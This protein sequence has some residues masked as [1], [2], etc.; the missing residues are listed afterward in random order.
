MRTEQEKDRALAML[1]S[2]F[3]SQDAMTQEFLAG[4]ITGIQW[5]FGDIEDLTERFSVSE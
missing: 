5:A 2:L 4:V 3:P 1:K